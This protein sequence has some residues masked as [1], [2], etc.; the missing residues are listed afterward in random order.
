MSQTAKRQSIKSYSFRTA[1]S[2]DVSDTAD[3]ASL[4]I[5]IGAGVLDN[6]P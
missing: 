3:D 1:A 5:S 6:A 2:V 4:E